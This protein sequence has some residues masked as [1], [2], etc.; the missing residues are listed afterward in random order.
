[1][2]ARSLPLLLLPLGATAQP[3]STI[4]DPIG[5]AGLLQVVVALALV[6][7]LFLLLAWIMRRLGGLHPGGNGPIRL[8]AGISVG[9]RERVILVQVGEQQLLLGVA[10][11]RVNTLH[12][13]EQKIEPPPE[14]EGFAA[15]LDALVNRRERTP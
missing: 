9:Q 6:L 5:T 7:G 14:G 4:P 12:V 15:R 3:T 2:I 1:M 10:P 13:L 11:G 8:I